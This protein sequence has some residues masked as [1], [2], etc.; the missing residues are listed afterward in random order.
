MKRLG[1]MKMTTDY[2]RSAVRRIQ[3]PLP[4]LETALF[5]A[6]MVMLAYSG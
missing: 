2:I 4:L 1:A 5:M 3:M 6:L